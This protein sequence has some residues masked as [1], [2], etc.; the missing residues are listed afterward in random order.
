MI[1]E[2]KNRYI[3]YTRHPYG[4]YGGTSPKGLDDFEQ[5][6]KRFHIEVSGTGSDSVEKFFA[7]RSENKKA[8]VYI[9]VEQE[10]E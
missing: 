7:S 1:D 2:S 9:V 6:L 10:T 3:E 5:R 4:D 8:D